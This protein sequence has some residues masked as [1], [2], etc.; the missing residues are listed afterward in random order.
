[1][2]KRWLAALGGMMA[3]SAL[4]TTAEAGPLAGGVAG[5]K[6]EAGEVS[7][8]TQVHHRRRCHCQGSYRCPG[9]RVY[10][11]SYGYVAPTPSIYLGFGGWRPYHRH[12]HHHWRR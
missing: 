3:L 6:S 2:T 8:L 9:V 7:T 10:G 12:H 11:Y 1:M 5:L 4:A